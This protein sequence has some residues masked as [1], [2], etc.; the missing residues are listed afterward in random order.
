MLVQLEAVH[1]QRRLVG[2]VMLVEGM[3]L[4]EAAPRPNPRGRMLHIQFQEASEE[5]L[6]TMM[7][8]LVGQRL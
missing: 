1:G 8:R 3:V 2:N 5:V 6:L 4:L 7:V